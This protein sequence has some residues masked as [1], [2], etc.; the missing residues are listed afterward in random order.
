M[1]YCW[2]QA[3]AVVSMGAFENA[4][5]ILLAASTVGDAHS[6]CAHSRNISYQKSSMMCRL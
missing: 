4:V 6:C 5:K 3:A 2:S 1:S